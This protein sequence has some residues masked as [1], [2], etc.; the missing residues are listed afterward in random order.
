MKKTW[1]I[2]KWCKSI[3]DDGKD[4]YINKDI[5]KSNMQYKFRILDDDGIVY[6]YGVSEKINFKPLNRYMNS[7]GV[8]EIQ[9]K[10]NGK[11]KVL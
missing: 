3:T 2:T 1:C 6:G 8:T 4:K 9:Y 5:D 10:N 7:L 11:Y